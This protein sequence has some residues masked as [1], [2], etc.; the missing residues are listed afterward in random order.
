M[1]GEASPGWYV[2][3]TYLDHENDRFLTL[4]R[5]APVGDRGFELN[6]AAVRGAW[7]DL[8]Q[9]PDLNARILAD[10]FSP[11]GMVDNRAITAA[12]VQEALGR[13]INCLLKKA[14]LVADEEQK[15][16]AAALN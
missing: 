6:E 8:E 14:R 3:F 9:D 5:A 1:V 11:E 16:F 13:C 4:G 2:Q 7:L 10:L 15:R 12:A